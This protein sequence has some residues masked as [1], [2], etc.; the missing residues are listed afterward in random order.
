MKKRNVRPEMFSTLINGYWILN[1]NYYEGYVPCSLTE[2]TRYLGRP[3]LKTV[4]IGYY[5]EDGKR[6]EDRK[7]VAWVSYLALCYWISAAFLCK[8]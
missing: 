5:G 2:A 3:Y 1:E 6:V 4:S 8:I 7:D